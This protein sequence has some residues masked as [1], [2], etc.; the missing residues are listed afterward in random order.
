M[1]RVALEGIL[2][3]F[4][5]TAL[6]A[7]CVFFMRR[8]PKTARRFGNIPKQ[9]GENRPT[10]GFPGASLRALGVPVGRFSTLIA[11]YYAEISNAVKST[12]G[13]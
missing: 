1:I 6:G 10:K 7:A 4:L 8:E 12:N 5:G 9:K 2:I 11:F 13:F 3:P